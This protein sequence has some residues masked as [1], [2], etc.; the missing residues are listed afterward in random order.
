M[1]LP[2]QR[3]A[4]LLTL[5][6]TALLLPGRAEDPRLQLTPEE[7]PLQSNSLAVAL[8]EMLEYSQDRGLLLEK[9]AAQLP[10]C[11]VGERCAM[12]HGPR[13]GKLCDCLRG[14][15]CNSFMLRCY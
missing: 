5:C 7:L 12:K 3:T 13:I 8:G 15:S 9:K 1:G 14:A 10:R 6:L 11:D 2:K 4:L